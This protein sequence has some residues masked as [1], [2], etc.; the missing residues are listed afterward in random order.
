MLVDTS[1]LLCCFDGDDAR[2]DE[3]VVLFDRGTQRFTHNY[4]LLEFVA[5]A[6]ARRLPAKRH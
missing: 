1:G 4:V 6:Q 2:H 5:L 3:A